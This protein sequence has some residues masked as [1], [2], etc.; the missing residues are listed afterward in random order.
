VRTGRFALGALV[1]LIVA[2]ITWH[3]ATADRGS[4]Y[5]TKPPMIYTKLAKGCHSSFYVPDHSTP[6]A[7]VGGS[8]RQ[9]VTTYVD[10][11]YSNQMGYPRDGWV[12]VRRNGYVDTFES[13]HAR[14]YA[15]QLQSSAWEIFGGE[16]C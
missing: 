1:A 4:P 6:S 2:G 13:G 14:L 8:P 7:F 10:F 11:E 15:I 12:F 5:K 16:V 3:Y 9:A